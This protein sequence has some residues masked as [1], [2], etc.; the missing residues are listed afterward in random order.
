M[1]WR[2][3][4][5]SWHIRPSHTWEKKKGKHC[6]NHVLQLLWCNCILDHALQHWCT[7]RNC[8]DAIPLHNLHLRLSIYYLQAFKVFLHCWIHQWVPWW[9]AQRANRELCHKVVLQQSRDTQYQ[10]DLWGPNCINQ[11][12]TGLDTQHWHPI[13]EGTVQT[14]SWGDPDLSVCET[15]SCRSP[16][17]LE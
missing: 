11:Y 3:P 15:G 6:E 16:I 14:S 8:T 10:Q 5:F 1:E 4:S 9:G 7:S 12:T 17:S 2:M 13:Q